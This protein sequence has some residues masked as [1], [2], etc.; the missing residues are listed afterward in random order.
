[1]KG[2]ADEAVE[3][4]GHVIRWVVP[5]YDWVN[6][7]ILLDR[8]YRRLLAEH[9]ALEPGQTLVDVGC[10]TGSLLLLA[11]ESL[12]GKAVAVGFDPSAPMLDRARAK[13]RRLGLEVAFRPGVI[14][15][16]PVPDSSA[17][18]VFCTLMVHHLPADV[19]AQGLA[20]IRRVLK[21]GGFALIVDFSAVRNPLFLALF[22]VHFLNRSFRRQILGGLEPVVRA[23][24]F[25]RV[26]RLGRW[27]GAVDVLRAAADVAGSGRDR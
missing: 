11:Q 25:A 5:I 2:P 8:R 19:Q 27:M 12:Q 16:I 23:A 10:G 9:G 4:S 24:G 13:A 15:A 22:S 7:L 1:M 3:T 6:R 21:P 18:R 20:E 17:D 14:E 26:D